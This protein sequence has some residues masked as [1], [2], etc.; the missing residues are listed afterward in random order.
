MMR[1]IGGEPRDCTKRVRDLCKLTRFPEDAL[2]KY[3][4]E[5][6]GG[7]RQRV[8][9]MRALCLDPKT[10]LLDEPL[11]ALDPIVRNE[12]QTE[13]K[14]IFAKLKKTVILVTHD[15]GEAAYLA[16][17]IVLMKE[18]QVVQEGKLE[19]FKSKPESEF[20][21]QFLNSQRS[22]VTI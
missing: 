20:V 7:Q 14:E 2:S 10:L 3:P 9:L 8:G 19:D 11:G 5:L 12:L 1:H 15:M 21:T 22:L 13:L 6:S 16:D 17:T 4:G 18:G